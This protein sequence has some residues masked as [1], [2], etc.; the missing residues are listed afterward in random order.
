MR[1]M[2]GCDWAGE[3]V[4]G[5]W[6]SEKLDGWRCIWTGAE[7]LSRQGDTF[8]VPPWWREGMPDRVLDGELWAGPGTTHDQVNGAVRSG[9]WRA[10]AFRPFDVPV[11][12]MRIEAA[13]EILAGLSLPAH[14]R[15]VTCSLVESTAAAIGA[16]LAIV[17]AGGEGL[18]LRA[19][20]SAYYTDR[21]SRN[22][23]KLVPSLEGTNCSLSLFSA[24]NFAPGLLIARPDSEAGQTWWG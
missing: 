10:L 24:Q 7:F 8:K 3:D 16:M 22:L 17:A 2:H 9:N 20:N 13:R 4:A 1:L 18:M 6:A 11:P 15:P 21:R 19:P 23:L 12:G 5:W 14:A